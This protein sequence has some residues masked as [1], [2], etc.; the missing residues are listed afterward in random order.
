MR[1]PLL[2]ALTVLTALALASGSALAAISTIGNATGI[3]IPQ[4]GIATH[5]GSNVAF[6][7]S[8][9]TLNGLD[10]SAPITDVNVK[11]NDFSH[12]YPDDVGVLLVGPQSTKV[13]LMADVGG[14]VGQQT[15]PAVT[16]VNLVLDDEA[17]VSLPDE[18]KITS[19]TYR[20]T[21][22]TAP[23]GGGKAVNFPP[24]AP[25][26][27]Y[28]QT[29]SLLDN[30]NPNGTWSLYVVDDS[31]TFSGQFA[32]GW[33][34]E[35]RTDTTPPRV[36]STTPKAEATGVAPTANVKATFSEDMKGASVISSFELFR[37]GSTRKVGASV[38]YDSATRKGILDP[39]N[40][41]RRGAT[42]KA[43]VNTSAQDLHGLRLDQNKT[44]SGL[45]KKVW[46]FKA[47]N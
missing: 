9:I 31:P 5:Q 32:G 10:P 19:G 41:L 33:L 28:A 35:I 18:G 20:P 14:G 23:S 29:L 36:I 42:Y 4:E 13:L 43:V 27:P 21:Q 25:A 24:P 40:P 11:L 37:K 16:N 45:Q 7:P 34:L 8:Q 46:F 2:V 12:T 1:R 17:L 38:S 15:L 44:L 26:G 22:G 6:Y 39:T 30:T 47:R 3:G